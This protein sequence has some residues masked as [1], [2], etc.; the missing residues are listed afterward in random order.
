[1]IFNSRSVCLV[2]AK[3]NYIKYKGELHMN[4]KKNCVQKIQ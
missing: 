2:V 3:F 1:M 4:T